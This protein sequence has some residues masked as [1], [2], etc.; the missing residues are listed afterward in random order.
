MDAKVRETLEKQLQLLSE[1][2]NDQNISA[3]DLRD[4]T[5]AMVSVSMVLLGP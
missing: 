2:S 5:S 3:G 4:L 1:R